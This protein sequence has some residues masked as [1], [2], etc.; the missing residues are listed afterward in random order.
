[1]DPDQLLESIREQFGESGDME[2]LSELFE[3][4]D[5]WLKRGGFLPKDWAKVRSQTRSGKHWTGEARIPRMTYAQRDRL[6]E[7]CGNYGVH[8]DEK[9]YQVN[10]LT[11]NMM[12]GW[13]E[14]WIGG[15]PGTIYVGVSPEGESHS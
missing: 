15:E 1:M 13:V 3:A 8:F 9:H 2:M 5:E 11:S 4:M 7:M 12:P 6:W 14:G 10:L